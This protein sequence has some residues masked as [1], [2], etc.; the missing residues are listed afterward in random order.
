[1]T[2]KEAFEQLYLMNKYP[3]KYKDVIF[4]IFEV[5]YNAVYHKMI[6]DKLDIYILEPDVI[7]NYICQEHFNNMVPLKEEQREEMLK[8][9]SYI[10]RLITIVIDKIYINEFKGYEIPKLINPYNPL[11][12]TYQFFLNFILNRFDNI[13]KTNN[14][15]DAIL[16]DVLKK[17]FTISKGVVSL[18]ADGFETEAFSTWRT[19]HE[20]E[21]VAIILDKFPY[22]SNVYLNHMKYNQL[23]RKTEK[24]EETDKFYENIKT[25]LKEHN[26]KSKDFKKYLEYGFLFS[27]ENWENDYPEMKLNFRKGIQYVAELSNYSNIYEASSEIAHGSSLLIY[28]NKSYYCNLTLICLYET[29]MRMESI[30]SN[31]ISNISEV[32]S[33]AYFQMKQIYIEEFNKNL[34][35]LKLITKIETERKK[36]MRSK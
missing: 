26:L 3:E 4:P 31:I 11:I 18:V 5:V 19:L 15:E 29:F 13:P 23:Y 22:L 6:E 1:M 36:Q 35:K 28:S 24:N 32:D 9:E 7:V 34:I 27:I 12:T 10:N 25:K 16:L 2:R 21:C 20:I 17:S 14:I 30:F 8:N 33:S